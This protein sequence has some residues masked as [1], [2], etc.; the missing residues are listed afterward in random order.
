MVTKQMLRSDTMDRKIWRDM[1]A[2]ALK[3]HVIKK[4]ILNG[5]ISFGSSSTVAKLFLELARLRVC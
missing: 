5:A 2:H 1:I 4:K 3:G